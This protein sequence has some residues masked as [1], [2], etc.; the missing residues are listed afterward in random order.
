MRW[1][2]ALLLAPLL[3]FVTALS[4]AG[5]RLLVV[6]EEA[7]DEK[8]YSQFFDDLKGE[9]P[10]MANHNSADRIQLEDTLFRSNLPKMINW[11]YSN[12]GNVNM[13]MFCYYLP[14]QKVGTCILSP[15]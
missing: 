13:T 12:M 11:L 5:S 6:N 10:A 14:N 1:S 8:K 2:T 7:A 4:S 9:P 3:S 15:G